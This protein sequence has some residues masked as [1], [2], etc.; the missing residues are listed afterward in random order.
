MILSFLV[1][2]LS[3]RQ[4]LAQNATDEKLFHLNHL[5]RIIHQDKLHL[6]RRYLTHPPSVCMVELLPPSQCEKNHTTPDEKNHEWQGLQENFYRNWIRT[7]YKQKAECSKDRNTTFV[8]FSVHVDYCAPET[9]PYGGPPSEFWAKIE[10]K[11]TDFIEK[12][13][14][15]RFSLD[16]SFVVSTNIFRA[17][18][19]HILFDR[20]LQDI[21]FLRLDQIYPVNGREIFVPYAIDARKFPPKPVLLHHNGSSSPTAFVEKKY[22]IFAPC[23]EAPDEGHNRIRNWKPRAFPLLKNVEDS[24]IVKNQTSHFNFV[25]KNSVFCLI[26]PGD[27]PSTSKIYKSIFS[28]CIPV[29]FV[30]HMAQLPFHTVLNWF[31]FSV[32]VIREVIHSQEEMDK[33][34]H[35]LRILR[36]DKTHLQHLRENLAVVSDVFNYSRIDFPNPFDFTII[37]MLDTNFCQSKSFPSEN[38]ICNYE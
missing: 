12:S 2:F 30:A 18:Y 16:N 22:F 6:V 23:N 25:M 26:F 33:V 14:P 4:R 13:A 17:P 7:K 27:T 29:V 19:P 1:L 11:V 21:R 9:G 37:T 10:E 35:R 36:E 34:I 28:G 20:N 8:M 31:T 15:P 32:V 24:V 3:L 5:R 38:L